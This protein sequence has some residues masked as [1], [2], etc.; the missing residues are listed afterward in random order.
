MVPLDEVRGWW[1][2]HHLFADLLRA[3][4]EQE[5]R[6]VGRL[7]RNA[8]AWYEEHGL[9]DDGIHHAAAARDM[10]WAARLIEQHFDVV[11]F[12]RGEEAT[13]HRWL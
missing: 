6:K 13:I 10:T 9:T 8:A 12:V 7:H 3:R 4:V 5:P 1:R 11:F 2:Y